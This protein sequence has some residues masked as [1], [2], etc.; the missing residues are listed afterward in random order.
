[1]NSKGNRF[2]MS[3]MWIGGSGDGGGQKTNFPFCLMA[4]TLDARTGA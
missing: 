3:T 1:M 2:A 4:V